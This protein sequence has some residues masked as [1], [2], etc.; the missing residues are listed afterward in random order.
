MSKKITA[1]DLGITGVMSPEDISAREGFLDRASD[2]VKSLGTGTAGVVET[3]AGFLDWGANKL[4]KAVTG[5]GLDDD[6]YITP[7]VTKYVEPIRQNI[8]NSKSMTHQLEQQGFDRATS[9][10]DDVQNALSGVGY[11]AT[12][13]LYALDKGVEQL[14]NMIP[15]ARG[16]SV[17][18]A[19][20]KRAVQKGIAKDLMGKGLS[21]PAAL[22]V[23]NRVIAEGSSEGAKRAI[24]AGA[25]AGVYATSAPL[26]IGG[27]A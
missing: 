27:I 8:E 24:K 1:A 17:G 16:A 6:E 3:G 10:D 26:L 23:A 7:S 12:H 19:V 22:D 14:P 5:K 18:A 9:S 25:G 13:P 11:L 20:T 4:K 2:A 15:M 21:R